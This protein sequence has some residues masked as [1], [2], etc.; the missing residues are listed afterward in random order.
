MSIFS[1]PR[2]SD[3]TE[4]RRKGSKIVLNVEGK[5]TRKQE[6]LLNEMK[7]NQRKFGLVLL[8]RLAPSCVDDSL[9][10]QR[11]SA[12]NFP[13]N[14]FIFCLATIGNSVKSRKSDQLLVCNSIL[15]Q[16]K[17]MLM[18]L[19]KRCFRATSVESSISFK[20]HNI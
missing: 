1:M 14:L 20:A 7:F 9:R 17:E 10:I 3:M 2:L 16:L 18:L 13:S 15:M 4:R 12:R 11:T 8:L 5:R 6:L 19:A